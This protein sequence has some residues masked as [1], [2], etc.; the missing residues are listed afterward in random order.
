VV[1]KFE[2]IITAKDPIFILVLAIAPAENIDIEGD[3][4]Q[5]WQGLYRQ[6]RSI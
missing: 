3:G 5:C 1:P 2:P 6:R 4:G